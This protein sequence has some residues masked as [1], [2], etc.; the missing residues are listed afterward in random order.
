MFWGGPGG[1]AAQPPGPVHLQRTVLPCIGKVQD[2]AQGSLFG[3]LGLRGTLVGLLLTLKSCPCSATPVLRH[4]QEPCGPCN[5]H[6]A[7]LV[8][9]Q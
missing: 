6:T 5:V 7:C 1:P 9:K 4:S 3:V 8:G 2:W